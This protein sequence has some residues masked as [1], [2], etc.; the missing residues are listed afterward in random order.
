MDVPL[1]CS[2]LKCLLGTRY[3]PF[4]PKWDISNLQLS[5][6]IQD[7]GIRQ[8]SAGEQKHLEYESGASGKF[9]SV[10]LQRRMSSLDSM[11]PCHLHLNSGNAIGDY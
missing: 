5:S 3:L 9:Q 8:N 6:S 2:C 7:P 10:L 1:P 11:M 4:L